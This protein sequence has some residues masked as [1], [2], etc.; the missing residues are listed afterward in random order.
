MDNTI[1]EIREIAQRQGYILA[2]TDFVN[3][4][5]EELAEG[6]AE[7]AVRLYEELAKLA[8]LNCIPFQSL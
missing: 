6:D 3:L 7:C 4:L 5:K 8:K 2:L 1:N